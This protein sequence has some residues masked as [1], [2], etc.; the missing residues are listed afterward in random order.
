MVVYSQKHFYFMLIIRSRNQ[1][2]LLTTVHF[3]LVV[4]IVEKKIFCGVKKMIHYL[5]VS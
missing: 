3:D 1:K 4:E 5:S 2:I